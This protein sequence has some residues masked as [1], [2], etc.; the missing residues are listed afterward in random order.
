MKR[1]AKKPR[2]TVKAGVSIDNSSVGGPYTDHFVEARIG[3]LSNSWK[4]DPTA[5]GIKVHVEEWSR[6]KNRDV[7]LYV[8]IQRNSQR[9]C[10]DGPMVTLDH[11][12]ALVELLTIARDRARETFFAERVPKERARKAG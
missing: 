2:M 4:T 1:P 12:D 5:D 7:Y 9:Y 6:E 3:K 10:L 8:E 11:L